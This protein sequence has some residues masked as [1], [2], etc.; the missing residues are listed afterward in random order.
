MK[1]LILLLA[2]SVCVPA[3]AQERTESVTTHFQG[4][5]D[6][7]KG[8]QL[9]SEA[10]RVARLIQTKQYQAA[11]DG[12]AALRKRYEALFDPALRQLTFASRSEFDDFKKTVSGKVEWIDWGYKECLHMQAF[13]A[14]QRRDFGSA[15]TL[16][17][18][19]EKVAPVSA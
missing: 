2:L 9:R 7:G 8:A 19:I 4:S 15:L 10:N 1:A 11:A 13:L 5:A 18:D 6:L 16:L 3:C 12:A 17:N 14:A